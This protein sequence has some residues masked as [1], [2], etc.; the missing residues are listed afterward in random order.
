MNPYQFLKEINAAIQQRG[1][2][3]RVLEAKYHQTKSKEQK[4]FDSTD[5]NRFDFQ[6]DKSFNVINNTGN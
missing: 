4:G 2:D 6:V 3:I 5:S 1:M